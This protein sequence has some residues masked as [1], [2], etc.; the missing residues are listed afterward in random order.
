MKKFFVI[1]AFLALNTSAQ[2]VIVKKDGS[3]IL[4]KVLEVNTA[5]IKYKKFSNQSGPIYTLNKSEI[6]S[7]NY[8][9]GE[10]DMFDRDTPTTEVTGSSSFQYIKKEADFRNAE[11]LSLYNRKYELKARSR[12]DDS[13]AKQCMI[14]MGVHSSSVMSTDDIEMTFERKELVGYAVYVINLKNKTD[15]VIFIDKG[16]SFKVYNDDASFCYY[17]MTKQTTYTHGGSV[18]A[19]LAVGSVANI[20]GIG[21][22]AGQL[23][24]GINIGGANTNSVSTTIAQQRYIAIPPHGSKNLT[25]EKWLKMGNKEKLVEQAESFS[26]GNDDI[27]KEIKV[28]RGLK[29]GE[30]STYSEN[31]SPWKREFF[32]TYSTTEDFATYSTLNAKLYI[33]EFIGCKANDSIEGSNKYTLV[34]GQATHKR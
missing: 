25:D 14:I 12:M 28:T 34:T 32:I 8:E 9:N 22:L 13:E 19:S 20:M 29:N 2:D 23:A 7:I 6:M 15:K 10:M 24:Q 3:T 17:D 4:S 30:I 11:I 5:D 18:G 1:L 16:N 31:E 27:K 26:W 21:G 33:S